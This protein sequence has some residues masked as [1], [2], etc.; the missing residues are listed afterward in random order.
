MK[1]TKFL[2]FIILFTCASSFL[3]SAEYNSFVALLKSENSIN[4]LKALNIDGLSFQKAIPTLDRNLKIDRS[5]SSKQALLT[6]A[7]G[8]YYVINLRDKTDISKI[9][10]SGEVINIEPNYLYKIEDIAPNDEFYGEQWALDNINAEAAWEKASGKNI[11]IGVLDTGIDF[12]HEDLKNQLWIN[13]KEDIN[14]NGKFD[15]WS[16]AKDIDG[17]FGDFDGIDND[18]NGFIDDVIGYDFIDQKVAN[19]GDYSVPDPI[20]ADEHGHGTL[21]SGV[22]SAE[23]NNEKGISG[24]AYSSKIM[25]LRVFDITGNGENDDIANAVIYAVLNG[26]KVLNFSFGEEVPSQLMRDAVKFAYE[27]GCVMIASSGNNG[28]QYSHYPSGYDEVISVGYSNVKNNREYRSNYGSNLDILAPG[29]NILTTD[30]GDTYRPASGSSL[31]APFASATAA[32]LLE[33]DDSASPE[34]IKGILQASARD[35]EDQGWDP[36]TGSGILDA[37]AAVNTIGK[38]NIAFIYPGTDE[39]I[40]KDTVSSIPIALSIA[41]PLFDN[42]LIMLGEGRLPAST[43]TKPDVWDTLVSNI[44]RQIIN[45]PIVFFS[46]EDL[47]DTV[48][49]LRL[50]INLKN[51]NTIERRVNFEIASSKYQFGYYTFRADPILKNG[52]RELMVSAISNYPAK[53]MVK[54]RRK[55]SDGPYFQISEYGHYDYYHSLTIADT[56]YGYEY[57]AQAIAI[58]NNSDTIKKEFTFI[59]PFE[60][61]PIDKFARKP[62]SIPMSYILN[63][64]GDIFGDGAPAFALNDISN[65]NWESTKIYQ[66]KNNEMILK[67]SI[68]EIWVPVGYG[69]SNGDGIMEVFSKSGGESILFQANQ[70]GGA[71]YAGKIFEKIHTNNFWAVDMYD[72]DRDGKEELLANSDTALH[73]YSYKNGAYV[74]IAATYLP[75]DEESPLGTLPGVTVGDFDNDGFIE[76]CHSNNEGNLFIY[77]FK[78]GAF[79][80]EFIDNT[81]I[82]SSSQYMCSA[83][84]NGDGV[85]EVVNGNS[86]SYPLYGYHE[87]GSPV[88]SFRILQSDGADN[89]KVIWTEEVYGVRS[90]SSK[91]ISYRNG[92]AAGDLDNAAGDEVIVSAF[93][94][95]YVL[96]WNDNSHDMDVL[97]TYPNAYANSAIIYDFDG[98]GINELGFTNWNSTNFYEFS[99]SYIGPRTPTGFD[100]YALDSSTAYLYWDDMDGADKYELIVLTEDFAGYSIGFF[101]DNEATINNFDAYGVNTFV[102]RSINETDTSE[103]SNSL[104]I[105][106]HNSYSAVAAYQK[107]QKQLLVSFNG[108]LPSTPLEPSL[109]IL[110]SGDSDNISPYTVIRANDT[111]ALLSFQSNIAP[112]EYALEAKSFKDYYRMPTNESNI[113]ITINQH[114]IPEDELYLKKLTVVSLTRLLL[115]YSESIGSMSSLDKN[116]YHFYPF[117]E[118]KNISLDP[119]NDK[120]VF[121]DLDPDFSIGARG[122]EY[123]LQVDNVS[124]NSGNIITEGAGNTLSF[125][126]FEN[127]LDKVY[128]YPNPIKLNEDPDIYF[129][130]LTKYAEVTIMT[131]K[132]EVLRT[133][134]ESDGNG[135]VEWDGRDAHGNKLN[136]GVYLYKVS[137]K[138]NQGDTFDS[139]LKKIMIIR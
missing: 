14:N 90:G 64:V 86:G 107:T 59:S 66:F 54:Y 2:S 23:H 131:L 110:I 52:A 51:Q 72:M 16:S 137:G 101:D 135:G 71:P 117:G 77:Q 56:E 122:I 127:S 114:S 46:T 61:L 63:D 124:A 138:N 11:V 4:K 93:P 118:A 73:V 98:N 13:S 132:G 121:I 47:K 105:Y 31:A 97:W 83:D 106:L 26:A 3:N 44:D 74:E 55:G 38:T 41:T 120:Q 94:N 69:D 102:V 111:L 84:I 79:E 75:H 67:D 21:V 130:N 6:E 48:Y 40:N 17:V 57:E 99:S 19:I 68:G 128:V 100:G 39:I 139:S 9:N 60:S 37:G 22:I 29:A 45:E 129:A 5:L 116:N 25:S 119:E 34:D 12:D 15:P 30:M 136:S 115:T 112:G 85:P 50:L 65:G 1:F 81:E 108:K 58:R 96:K 91:Y 20:P 28:W 32:L 133:L 95:L 27:S 62:Y 70:K 126:F 53:F 36:K 18:G 113:D 78:D 76:V 103:I 125:V 104:D 35:I 134:T 49:T 24:L 123:A 109:F 43:N 88:W 33:T 7:L 82:S 10:A 42:F 89:Y 87:V 80:I 92:I 8:R